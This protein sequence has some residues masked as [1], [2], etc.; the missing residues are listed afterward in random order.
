[1]IAHLKSKKSMPWKIS[2]GKPSPVSSHQSE[3]V[4]GTG[5]L[6]VCACCIM[7]QGWTGALV[8]IEGKINGS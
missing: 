1:M 4:N 7:L 6:K 5:M 3:S 8:R 2:E